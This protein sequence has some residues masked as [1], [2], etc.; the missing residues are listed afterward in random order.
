MYVYMNI[1]ISKYVFQ[2]D[3][4]DGIA[5][6]LL[7]L[8]NWF[9]HIS[10]TTRNISDALTINRTA[11]NYHI[12]ATC[13]CPGPQNATKISTDFLIEENIINATTV[14]KFIF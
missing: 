14:S 2:H 7:C 12:S 13:L 1:V 5:L 11:N 8:E 9:Y 3:P 6:D 10:Q 4:K